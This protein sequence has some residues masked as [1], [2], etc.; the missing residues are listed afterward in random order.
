MATKL[1]RT[2]G[3]PAA[4][5]AESENPYDAWIAQQIERMNTM[6]AKPMYS[7]EEV[8]QRREANEREYQLGVLGMLSGLDPLKQAGGHVLKN[9]LAQR[10][11]RVTE[12]GVADP[13]SGRFNYDPG[14]LQEREQGKLEVLQRAKAAADLQRG[15]Q[16]ERLQNQQILKQIAA[17]AAG[18]G[19]VG[20]G[21]AS[22]VGADD[23]GNPVFRGK[24]GQLFKYGPDGQPLAHTG[25]ILPKPSGA[26]TDDE[27][28]AS[29]WLGSAE[30]G[31]ADLQKV[32]KED[33][34]ASQ[35]PLWEKVVGGVPRVGPDAANALRGHHRQ[36]F[37]QSSKVL[38]EAML[39]AATGAGY[40][41]LEAK[42]S[43]EMLTPIYGE[44]P[45]TTKQKLEGIPLFLK[46][47]RARA[48]R[49]ALP[50]Y[51]GSGNTPGADAGGGG[52]ASDPL[53]LL[54]GQ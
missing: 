25:S 46:N 24:S 34:D 29:M 20:T 3:A 5:P 49:A 7:D 41:Y 38:S 51:P 14:Y 42:D 32:V 10:Q 28:K 52:D 11:P 16:T 30:K 31:W 40:N 6:Q 37:I 45:E 13:I 33:P 27:R 19:G 47:L 39:R 26:T 35:I 21:T 22:Q 12:R 50:A 54:G 44:A 4:A 1:T 23:K 43:V 2:L 9:A 17:G 36:R 15:M 18:G 53:G 48:G 8:A